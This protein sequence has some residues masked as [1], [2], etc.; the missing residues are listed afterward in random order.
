MANKKA[1]D[2]TTTTTA[3]KNRDEALEAAAA[4]YAEKKTATFISTIKRRIIS[5]NN[6]RIEFL[7]GSYT[8]PTLALAKRVINNSAFG[9][10][11]SMNS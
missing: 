8:A 7:N 2:A 3:I 1:V 5:T 11:I 6:G 10:E 9:R 4:L